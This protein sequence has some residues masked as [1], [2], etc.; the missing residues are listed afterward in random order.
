[1]SNI[2]DLPDE[3]LLAIFQWLDPGSITQLHLTCKRFYSLTESFS[4]KQWQ[5]Y[6]VDEIRCYIKSSCLSVEEITS[7]HFMLELWM[8][9]LLHFSVDVCSLILQA[10][11][12]E[13][14][15]SLYLI[16]IFFIS[17]RRLGF[18]HF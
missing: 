1:M 4:L 15:T 5:S 3:S 18:C 7:F 6:L 17:I 10:N 8:T 12:M 16:Y 2:T 11:Y 13:V 14:R 9:Y